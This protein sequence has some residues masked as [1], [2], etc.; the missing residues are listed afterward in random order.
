MCRHAGCEHARAKDKAGEKKKGASTPLGL[1]AGAVARLA[2][3]AAMGPPSV[4]PENNVRSASRSRNSSDDEAP[5][6]GHATPDMQAQQAPTEAATVQEAARSEDEIIPD[7]GQAVEPGAADESMPVDLESFGQIFLEQANA[8]MDNEIAAIKA[9]SDASITALSRQVHK[10]LRKQSE[11]TAKLADQ[12]AENRQQTER[13]RLQVAEVGH[14]AEAMARASS[15]IGL[16]Q[17]NAALRRNRAALRS[18][19]RQA[20]GRTRSQGRQAG[21]LAT[22]CI[23]LLTDGCMQSVMTSLQTRRHAALSSKPWGAEQ[24]QARWISD[25][26]VSW[27]RRVADGASPRSCWRRSY[28]E[29]GLPCTM[30]RMLWHHIAN[31]VAP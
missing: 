31:G 14:R 5:K 10:E 27:Q 30:S 11:A 19:T 16:I 8:R 12:V 7:S 3:Y 1:S 17:I 29:H 21:P 2:A 20:A 15:T 9:Q 18:A 22:E 24:V 25:N 6:S 23:Y 26:L 4:D 13:V 28:R